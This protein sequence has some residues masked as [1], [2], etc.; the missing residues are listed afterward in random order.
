MCEPLF[1][2]FRTSHTDVQLSFTS[3][4]SGGNLSTYAKL[5][6]GRKRINPTPDESGITVDGG[7]LAGGGGVGG[8]GGGGQP[9]DSPDSFTQQPVNGKRRRASCSPAGKSNNQPPS[10]RP[11]RP[12]CNRLAT[13]DWFG[14]T[15]GLKCVCVCI[16]STF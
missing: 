14:E 11:T 6:A 13:I 16:S 4:G 1:L 8:G 10:P 15:K 5:L 2:C 9:P 3:E 12:Y 7:R